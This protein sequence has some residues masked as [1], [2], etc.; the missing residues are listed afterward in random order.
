MPWTT[1]FDQ[2][3]TPHPKHLLKSRT[4]SWAKKHKISPSLCLL[5][6]DFH[7][8]DTFR[9]TIAEKRRKTCTCLQNHHNYNPSPQKYKSLRKTTHIYIYI[10]VYIY[11]CY[12]KKHIHNFTVLVVVG[13]QD[14]HHARTEKEKNVGLKSDNLMTSCLGPA[15]WRAR[16]FGNSMEFWFG[17]MWREGCAF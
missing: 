10:Y 15:T 11:K 5:R 17:R 9:I 8:K 7:K 14:S 12:S 2:K 3:E 4:N 1:T 6:K 16:M 13:S